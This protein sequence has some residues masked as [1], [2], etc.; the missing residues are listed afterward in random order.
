MTEQLKQ[1]V[2]LLVEGGIVVTMDAERHVYNPGYVA[3]QEGKII[4]TGCTTGCPYSTKQ[5]LDASNTIILPGIVNAHNHLDQS[6]YRS[7]WDR[8]HAARDMR[9][10]RRDMRMARGL[11]RERARAAATITLLEQVHYGI[12]TTHESHWTHYH[13][14]STDGIC[15]AIQ[16]SGM[17][18]VVGRCMC[19]KEEYMPADFCERI[20][21]VLDDLDRLEQEYESDRICITPEAGTILEC[22]PESMTALREWALR[23]GKI[24]HIHLAQNREELTEALRTVGMGSV[25]YAESLGLLG[26]EMLAVHCSGILDEEVEL[27]GNHQVRIVHCPTTVMRAGGQVPPIWELEKLGATV[28]IGTD[29]SA[30]TNGQNLWEAMKMAVYM[31]R[32][33][34]GDRFLGT[35]EQAL[36][37]ATIKA[38]RALDMDDRV[39]SLEPGKEAD[40]AMFRRD[41]LHLVMDARLINNLIYSGVPNLTDTVLVGGKVVLSGGRSTVFDEEEVRARAREAQTGMIKEAGLEEEIG[42][43]F[44]WPVITA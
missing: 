30:T 34:F 24:W 37:M 25:Q 17:R 33:R 2:D 5:R 32:V 27:L 42:L 20:E 35:A 31:Q 14:H 13:L 22:T 40:V 11:T 10:A 43:A 4:G 29:G 21:D 28:A 8:R 23:R 19:E 41:Q 1:D 18:A 38:A 26:P 9:M 7:C 12:T 3:I 6:V 44:S 36:E 16:K 39:G 15:E